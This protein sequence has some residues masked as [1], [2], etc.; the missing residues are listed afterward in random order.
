[1]KQLSDR[2]A[3]AKC[4]LLLACNVYL[5]WQMKKQAVA[6]H[7]MMSEVSAM[8]LAQKDD[9]HRR[10]EDLLSGNVAMNQSILALRARE[11]RSSRRKQSRKA[12]GADLVMAYVWNA[13]YSLGC[14]GW[15]RSFRSYRVVHDCY[16]DP[17]VRAVSN[18][19]LT[20]LQRL[21]CDGKASIHD[22]TEHG[23]SMLDVK[24]TL[25]S[26]VNYT[27]ESTQLAVDEYN[28]NVV[29]WLHQMGAASAGSVSSF[30][31]VL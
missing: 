31:P 21:I 19:N 3:S 12:A 14:R 7:Q 5:M 26:T 17:A 18:G 11:P 4:S 25:P 23:R 8:I 6:Q 9:H 16:K 30:I 24:H 27:N 22:R 15:T 20:A 1:M 2:V 10:F 28:M 13:L 29:R